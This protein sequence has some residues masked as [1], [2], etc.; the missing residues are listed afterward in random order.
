MS[1]DDGY[2][3]GPNSGV[4]FTIK[5]NVICYYFKISFSELCARAGVLESTARQAVQVGTNGFPATQSILCRLLHVVGVDF[6]WLLSGRTSD[7]APFDARRLELFEL[8]CE[9][10]VRARIPKSHR[11]LLFHELMPRLYARPIAVQGQA[12]RAPV[13]RSMLDMQ[14]EYQRLVAT[15][16][17]PRSN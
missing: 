6:S 4:D 11:T 8:I 16:A 1:M 17:S 14:Y 3:D 13:P 10:A 9:F 5:F 2:Y 7:L 15:Q 12:A